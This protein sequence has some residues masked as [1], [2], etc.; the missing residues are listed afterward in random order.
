MSF[1]MIIVISIRPG[2]E[3]LGRLP[4]TEMLRDT[5][6]YPMAVKT[7]WVAI[8]RVKSA[9]LCFSNDNFVME[10]YSPQYDELAN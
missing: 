7:P 2:T 4:G 8:V 1:A 5:R 9:L 10:R 6:Q 3:T